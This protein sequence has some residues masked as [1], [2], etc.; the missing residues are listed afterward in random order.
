M[1]RV[2]V[3]RDPLVTTTITDEFG[4]NLYATP[5]E[6]GPT[7]TSTVQFTWQRDKYLIT[8]NEIDRL[9][10]VAISETQGQFPYAFS[11]E[12]SDEI[13]HVAGTH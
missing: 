8:E 2:K 5:H 13:D 10:S 11:A 1:I 3:I 4:A 9:L 7:V 12:L 6:E